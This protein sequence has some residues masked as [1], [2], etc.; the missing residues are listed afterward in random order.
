MYE[1]RVKVVREHKLVLVAPEG[2]DDPS[3]VLLLCAIPFRQRAKTSGTSTWDAGESRVIHQML[4][5][6]EGTYQSPHHG[7][8]TRAHWNTR[9]VASM[10]TH[11]HARTPALIH[12]C[13][14][15]HTGTHTKDKRRLTQPAQECK[16]NRDDIKNVLIHECAHSSKLMFFHVTWL[17][18]YSKLIHELQLHC[19]GMGPVPCTMLLLG[20]YNP[21]MSSI[22]MRQTCQLP[23]P[24]R[25]PKVL[26]FGLETLSLFPKWTASNGRRHVL[27]ISL[28]HVYM[29]SQSRILGEMEQ[30][31]IIKAEKG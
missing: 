3:Q 1:R 9:P 24:G 25:S 17:H 30:C 22:S 21:S 8:Y 28:K 16:C 5:H 27:L 20:T 19:R 26:P 29:H 23:S 6:V 12:K 7:N 13:T 31:N 11:T 10:Y 2:S 4:W 18:M 15:M 14:H